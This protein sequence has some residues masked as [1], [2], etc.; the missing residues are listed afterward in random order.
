MAQVSGTVQDQDNLPII[1]VEVLIKGTDTVVYTNEDGVFEIDAKIGDILIVNDKEIVVTSNTLGI[2]KAIEKSNHNLQEVIVT[3][4]GTQTKESLTGSVAEVKADVI[5]DV[6]SANV[7][8]GLVG[9]VAG[10]QINSNNGLPGQAPTVRFRGIGSINGSSAPLYVVDGVPF[11]G[12]VSG[13]NNQDI[14]SISFLKDAS[15]A[16]LYGNRGA[17]GVIIITTKKGKKGKTRYN[18]DLR[19]GVSSRGISEYDIVSDPKAYYTTYH[20]LIKNTYSHLYNY[21]DATAGYW[22]SEYLIPYFLN[23]NITNV[24]GNKIVDA[25]GNF[26][27]DAKILYHEKW[28]DY[29]FKDGFYTNTYFSASGATDETNYF[30]STG[31]EKNSTFMTNATYEKITSRLKVDTKLGSRIKVGGNLAYS[32]MLQNAPDG[33]T[34]TFYYSNP[35][36]WSRNI[37][38]IYPVHAYD[39]DGNPIYNQHGDRV[40]DDGTGKY[41]GV[42]RPYGA[43]QNPYGTAIHDVKKNRYNQVFA[44]GYATVNII[45]GL[46][47]TYNV[48]GEFLNFSGKSADTT[49]FGDAVNA[50]GYLSN[51]MQNTTS[52]IQQQ[53]VTYKKRFG[54][55]NF[56]VLLGH[57]NL[58]RQVDYINVYG[59]NTLIEGSSYLALYSTLISGTNTGTPYA[60]EG[61]FARLNYDFANKYYINGNIRRDGSSRFH[62]DNRWGTFYG[63]GAAWRISQENFLKD[64]KIINELKIKGSYGEQGN[65]NLGYNFPYTDLY[66][67]YQSTENNGNPIN[68]TFKGNKNITWETNANINTGI[69]IGLLDNRITIDAEYFNRKSKDMLYMRPL[70]LSEGFASYPENIG[71]MKNYGYEITLNADVIRNDKFKLGLN[72]NFTSLKNKITHLPKNNII[73]G[74][75]ILREG[76]SMYSWY[77]REFAGVNSETGAAQFYIVDPTTG[78]KTITENYNSAT[79]Q[80]IGKNA[81]PKMY[82]GFGLNAEYKGIDFNVS[83][84]YQ[85]GGWGYDYEYMYFF[86][87]GIAESFH[88]DYSKTWTTNNKNASMPVV[89]DQNSKQYYSTSTLGLIKSD[90]I[91][92][93]NI[94]LGYTIKS[95]AIKNIGIDS[96]R[97]YAL[98]DNVYV[99]SKRK[100]YDPRMSYTGTSGTQFS[101]IR[102]IS[103]GVQ[104]SF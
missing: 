68:Q 30:F 91:S 50:S 3:A 81:V 38:A 34:G 101:P 33:Y 55:H 63:I 97:I 20:S 47:F 57:E 80:F 76:E 77:L 41:T 26:N 95:S 49:L 89:L 62:K 9:K 64:S 73:S 4:Y 39:K 54:K 21:N 90:Y 24:P 14:E 27:P 11:N 74:N 45:E 1:D 12:D 60:T 43:P 88:K 51:S 69:E 102:T 40:F 44:S 56:D 10:V 100:G 23:Y 93:Q 8:Q 36:L 6:T 103:G 82:G 29:L 85:T 99:W 79:L 52:F 5:A 98:A 42:V 15:A 2:I 86:D 72:F 87:G 58:D 53:L 25:D 92:L 17:N 67:V 94:S 7:I 70:N 104:F 35:F 37:G 16:A 83:F 19:T 71:D 75:Y 32:H 28:D 59:S 46:D 13:I 66:Y 96:F 22:A 65:D 78:E 84:A 31:Y 48:T 61:Y 18:L